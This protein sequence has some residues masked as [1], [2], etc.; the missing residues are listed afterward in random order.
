M[1]EESNV[2]VLR[3]CILGKSG[4]GRESGSQSQLFDALQVVPLE[5]LHRHGAA[6]ASEPRLLPL[7]R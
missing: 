2:K 5:T 6:I 7:G 4:N 1:N 3:Q